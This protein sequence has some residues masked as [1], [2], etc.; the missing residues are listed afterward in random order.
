MYMPYTNNPSLPKVRMEA[1]RLVRYRGWSMRKVARHIGVEPSTI[2]RWVRLDP[3]GGWRPVPTRSSRPLHHP[4]ELPEDVVGRILALRSE[5]HQCAAILHHRLQQEGVAVSLVSVKRTLQRYGCS[6]Y[7][8]WKK[9]HTYPP[10]PSPETPG[11]LIEIDTVLDGAPADRLCVYTLLDVCSRWA[12]AFP[13]LRTNTHES[14]R[15]VEGAREVAPFPFRTVQSDHGAEFSK[16]FTTQLS[17]RGVA[18]RHARIRTPN[19]NAHLERFN[20]TLQEECLCRTSR[21]LL[22]WRR[23]IPEYLRYYNE[24]RPH[25]GL[26][27]KTPAEVLRSY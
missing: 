25:M 20:R 17:F 2:L 13:C 7:S 12:Y 4:N 9:W 10:R 3:T 21:S 19:D 6:R 26:N 5:R 1:V 11:Q 15:F 23:E 22:A 24:E 8:R 16:W 27:M 18:H 14:L